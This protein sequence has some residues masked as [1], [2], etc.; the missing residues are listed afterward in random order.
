MSLQEQL[1]KIREASA[2]RVPEDKRAIMG[3]ATQELR[4]SGIMDGVI[5]V[6]DPLPPFALQNADGIEVRSA[7]L[8]AK[9]AVVM[10]VFRGHW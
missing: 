4:D 10:T 1:A 9:G 5:A 8:L 2:K 6:G 7:D 3:Q